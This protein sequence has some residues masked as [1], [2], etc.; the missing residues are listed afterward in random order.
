MASPLQTKILKALFVALRPLA[1]ALLKSGIGYKEF[2]DVAKVAFITEATACFG[3]RGRETNIS[4]VAVMTGIS[5]KQVKHFRDSSLQQFF[6]EDLRESPA[7]VVLS[8]WHSEVDFCDSEGLPRI[9]DYNDGEHSFASLVSRF[10]GDIPPGAIR[11][12]LRR[13]GAV[14]ELDESRL[15]VLKRYFVPTGIDERLIVGIEDVVGADLSTLAYNCDIENHGSPRFHRVT[16]IDGLDADKLHI[17]QAEAQK[18]L[19]QLSDSFD[20]YLIQM[21][22]TKKPNSEPENQVGIG[23]YYYELDR[24]K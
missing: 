1:R 13:V 15:K 3:V 21:A 24:T 20:D 16:S 17:V 10:V 6:G 9:L 18:R 2:S 8:R 11:A 5:R 12:E 4:R 7:S 23:L 19:S 22:S 14:E